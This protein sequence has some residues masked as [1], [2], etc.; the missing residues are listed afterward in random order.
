MRS[1]LVAYSCENIVDDCA[2][3]ERLQSGPPVA[4]RASSPNEDLYAQ[5]RCLS[6]S[7]LA[8]R[9]QVLSQSN[10]DV[11]FGDDQFQHE[12]KGMLV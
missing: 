2:A 11:Y 3:A 1:H 8:S 9:F 7:R 5:P 12:E 4:P 6:T 10:D